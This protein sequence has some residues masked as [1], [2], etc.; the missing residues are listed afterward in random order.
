[1]PKPFDE[2]RERLLRAG[3][4]PRHV[5][6]YVDELTDHLVDLRAEELRSGRKVADAESAA[7]ARLGEMDDLA[8]AILEQR[9]FQSWCARAPWAMFSLAPAVTLAA[10][11]AIALFI[12][13]SGWNMFLPG[14]DTPFGGH[15]V[16][17]FAN[18]YFQFGKAIYFFAP[19]LV[20][21]GVGVLAAHQRLKAIW[22]A[23]GLL[24]IALI[25]GASGVQADRTAVP[26]GFGHIRMSFTLAPS[27]QGGYPYGLV[28]AAILLTLTALPYLIWRLRKAHSRPT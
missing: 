12:L 19:I 6:R 5:R 3:V 8:K 7:L 11:W 2:L 25:G 28:H 9:H 17:G 20:G 14:A 24:L 1:M 16:G 21:W 13:W 27:I 15:Q 23:V 22:P 26:G 10:A 18:L 4:A